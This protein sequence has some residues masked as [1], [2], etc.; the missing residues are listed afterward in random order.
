MDWQ[1]DLVKC[2]GEADDEYKNSIE[3]HKKRE[4]LRDIAQM[5]ELELTGKDVEATLSEDGNWSEKYTIPKQFNRVGIEY[6]KMR[7]AEALGD[8]DRYNNYLNAFEAAKESFCAYYI[9]TH[10]SS[11]KAGWKNVL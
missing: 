7:A 8:F 2:I 1:F 11:K 10:G 6:I 5:L 4:W 3:E 9:R